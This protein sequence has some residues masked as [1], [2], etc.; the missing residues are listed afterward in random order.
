MNKT[1]I[2]QKYD[3]RRNLVIISHLILPKNPEFESLAL[4]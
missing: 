4:S 2:V 3:Y 1:V